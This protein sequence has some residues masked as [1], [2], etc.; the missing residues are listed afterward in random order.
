MDLRAM[1]ALAQFGDAQ[2]DRAGARL[3]IAAATAVALDEPLG[4]ALAMAAAGLGANLQLH[5]PL[6]GEADHLA[7]NIGVGG[8]LH[9][10]AKVHHLVGH[11]LVPR[12]R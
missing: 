7:Q 10:R 9:Q 6:G 11:R 3:P 12:L 8:L 4:G 1:G 2:L 5:Q